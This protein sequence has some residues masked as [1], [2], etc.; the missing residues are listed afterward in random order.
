MW[1]FQQAERV[2][3]EIVLGLGWELTADPSHQHLI[4]VESQYHDE[5]T[6]IAGTQVDVDGQMVTVDWNTAVRLIA[7]REAISTPC[8]LGQTPC[9]SPVAIFEPPHGDPLAQAFST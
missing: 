3:R 2:N 6:R 7:I 8:V 1:M 4:E 5:I 9:G